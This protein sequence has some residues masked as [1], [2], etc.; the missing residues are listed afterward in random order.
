MDETLLPL[1]A[2][3]PQQRFSNR[4]EDYAKYRPSY[5]AA[6]I[7][8]ILSGLEQP[9]VADVGAGTGISARLLAE[10][11]VK[12]WAIEPNAAMVAAAQPH[13][14]VEFRQGTAE[15]TGLDSRSVD[16][17]T[18]CQAFHW[19]EPSA[20]L[21]EF[22]RILNPGGRLALMWNERDETDEFTCEHNEIIRQAADRQFFDSPDRKSAAPLEESSLFKDFRVYSFPYSRPLNLEGIIGL[23]LS[24]SY[25]PKEGEAHDQMMGEFRSLYQRWAGRLDSV[26]LV[27]RTNLYLAEANSP[28]PSAPE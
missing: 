18:C 19:F 17:I 22:Q 2:Q 15:Q 14:L 11:S 10:R 12:V 13:P 6:A 4:A 23:A 16:V 28:P 8:Q 9:T 26:S 7:D 25:I 24:S 20:T 3:N 1:H 27:Y 21:S 5:P